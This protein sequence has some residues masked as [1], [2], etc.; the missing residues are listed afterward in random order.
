MELRWAVVAV[1]S[2]Q[3]KSYM[4]YMGCGLTKAK[5]DLKTNQPI[6]QFYDS[7]IKE[8]YAVPTHFVSSPK[9]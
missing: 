8:W 2:E 7:E 9:L 4:E 5:H 3:I 6:L 1:N